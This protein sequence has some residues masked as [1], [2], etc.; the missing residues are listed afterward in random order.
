[1]YSASCQSLS[2]S[3]V[4]CSLNTQDYCQHTFQGCRSTFGAQPLGLLC[5]AEPSTPEQPQQ[6]CA[7]TQFSAGYSATQSRCLAQGDAGSCQAAP[8]CSWVESKAGCAADLRDPLAAALLGAPARGAG[9]TALEQALGH[10]SAAA[11]AAVSAAAAA[12]NCSGPGA[13]WAT[14]AAAR[15]QEQMAARGGAGN[16]TAS[17]AGNATAGN[18]TGSSAPARAAAPARSTGEADEGAM[19]LLLLGQLPP[20]FAPQY[21]HIAQECAG[22]PSQEL[23]EAAPLLPDVC[24]E[25]AAAQA[26]AIKSLDT[27]LLPPAAAAAASGGAAGEG[28]SGLPGPWNATFIVAFILSAALLLVVG[29]A[30]PDVADWVKR[31]HQSAFAGY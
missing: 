28:L 30:W 25:A 13:S 20:A 29:S 31:Q 17:N 18:S 14:Q 27:G 11:A 24:P 21:L 23:C 1:M 6:E 8:G 9:S 22:R 16:A 5:R 10:G 2:S 26:A 19:F 12:A 7:A 3:L 15:G 4:N